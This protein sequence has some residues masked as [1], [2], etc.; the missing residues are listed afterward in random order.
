MIVSLHPQAH[1]FDQEGA[2]FIQHRACGTRVEVGANASAAVTGHLRSCPVSAV[3]E[4][5]VLVCRQC[6]EAFDSIEEAERHEPGACGSWQGFDI[7]VLDAHDNA[8]HHG[9]AR[10]L[11]TREVGSHMLGLGRGL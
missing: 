5:K 2:F 6:S 3:A 7:E 9:S 1:E 11:G 4:V 8:S 10:P